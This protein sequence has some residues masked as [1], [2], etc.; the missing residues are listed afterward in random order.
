[1]LDEVA[2]LVAEA[3]TNVV[4]LVPVTGDNMSTLSV[5]YQFRSIEHFGEATDKVGT[6][7]AFQALVA[8][9]AGL[10]KLRSASLMVPL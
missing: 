4:G 2:K 9:A 6:S 10:G 8:K 7:A 1:M 5:A 3:G